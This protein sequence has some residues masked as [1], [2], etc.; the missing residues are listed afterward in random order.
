MNEKEK[1]FK[2]P[3]LVLICDMIGSIFL[4]IGL[5]AHFADAHFIPEKLQVDNYGL[6]MIAIGIFLFVPL[7]I[8]LIRALSKSKVR[9]L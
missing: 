8:Y 5:A 2:P 9:E 4:G 3:L 1:K 7:V 6:K